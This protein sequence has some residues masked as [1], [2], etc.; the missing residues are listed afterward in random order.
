MKQLTPEETIDVNILIAMNKCMAELAHGLQ[1][2]HTQK[3]KQKIKHVI[4][5]VDVYEKEIDKSLERS[6]SKD[7]IETMY[8]CIMDLVLDAK[9]TAIKN[10]KA[11]ETLGNG[12]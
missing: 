5:I 8:D 1:Y 2:I 11:N 9:E 6:G 10:Y 3:L 12:L 4:R 7:A